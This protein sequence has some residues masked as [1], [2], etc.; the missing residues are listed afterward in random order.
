MGFMSRLYC[1]SESVSTHWMP[2]LTMTPGTG[3]PSRARSVPWMD[4][5]S[6]GF[7]SGFGSGLRGLG[8][9]FAA[10]RRITTTRRGFCPSAAA[11]FCCNVFTAKSIAAVHTTTSTTANMYFHFIVEFLFLCYVD[12]KL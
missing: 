8:A 3:V 9:G 2:L 5:G 7:G 11:R 10:R 12:A 6:S 1:P 4:V